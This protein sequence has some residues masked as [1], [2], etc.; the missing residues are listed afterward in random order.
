MPD[1]SLS[2]L[3]N[4]NVCPSLP[5]VTLPDVPSGASMGHMVTDDLSL[6]LSTLR[7]PSQMDLNHLS[8]WLNYNKARMEQLEKALVSQSEQVRRQRREREG[9]ERERVLGE[10]CFL[11][12]RVS[13]AFTVPACFSFFATSH[14]VATT[15]LLTLD[16]VVDGVSSHTYP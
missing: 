9:G 1:G 8:D 11:A 10:S 6:N 4:A 12:H 15:Q 14:I 13:L 2:T 5:L 3:S 7:E 16:F